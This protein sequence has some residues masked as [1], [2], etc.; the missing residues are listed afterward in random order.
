M[1]TAGEALE[2]LLGLLR[3]GGLAVD[4]ALAHHFGVAADHRPPI[5]F[6][7]HRP[8]LA[9]RVRDRVVFRLV[10]PGRDDVERDPELLED[11]PP[12]RRGRG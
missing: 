5:R 9:E 3:S 2:H 4:T 11:L 6:G 12:P 10:V 7:Q 8:S 1:G